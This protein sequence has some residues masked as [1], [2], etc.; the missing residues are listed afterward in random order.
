MS[1][2]QTRGKAIDARSDIWA[3]GCVLFEM[4]TG[5]RAFEGD[6]ISDTMAGIIGREPDWQALASP[7]SGVRP[8][9]VR[10]LKKDL[11][12]RLQ[13]IG[14]ARI[15][16]DEI[17]EGTGDATATIRAAPSTRARSMAKIAVVALVAGGFAAAWTWTVTRPPSE[18]GQLPWRFELASAPSEPLALNE[19][20]RVVAISPDG[21]SIVYVSGEGGTRRLVVRTIDR[22][23]ARPFPGIASAR[24]PFFS[25]DN[26]WI[27]FFD[28]VGNLK[29]VPVT[30]GP[31]VTVA[32]NSSYVSRGAS[33]ADDNSIVFAGQDGRGLKRLP[34]SG[35]APTSLTTP[36][37]ARGEANHWF[38]SVLPGGRGVLFTINGK[39]GLTR[40]QVAVL[41]LK[42][43]Q[44]RVLV[45]GSHAE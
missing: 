5:T 33:W 41:D 44:H 9:L 39:E 38:P 31:A 36:D 32:E 4:L 12:L 13:A 23:D 11:K 40:P 14:E 34:A 45:R 37:P 10:C 7:M 8:L 3:F 1:P 42:T 24:E 35:G 18:T 22:V 29:K 15:Q 28:N 17:I 26:R 19:T 20:G 16:I 30:G 21:R 25:P 2:E 6:T 27:G 43:G